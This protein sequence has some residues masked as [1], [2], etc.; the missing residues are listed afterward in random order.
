MPE[1]LIGLIERVTYHNPANGFAVLKV[2]VKSRQD[3]LTVVGSTTSATAG[4]HVEGTWRWVMD[5]E[6]RQQFKADELKT[7]HPASAEGIEK[8]LA[9]GAV[10]SIGPKVATKIVSTY[11]ERSLEILEI[12]PEYLL[13][14]RGIGR[15]RLKRIRQSWE[16]QKEVRKILL[17][18]AELSRGA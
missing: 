4:E 8:F 17:F 2:K 13:H 6:H 9:S 12:A 10:R 7:T 15:E 1:K 3:L 11:K 5:R 14:I 16:E 18:L